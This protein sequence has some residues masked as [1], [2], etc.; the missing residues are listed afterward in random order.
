MTA[1]KRGQRGDKGLHC[2]PTTSAPESP[3]G[4]CYGIPSQGGGVTRWGPHGWGIQ[5]KLAKFFSPNFFF[6]V[7][8]LWPQKELTSLEFPAWSTLPA[9]RGPGGGGADHPSA[10]LPK[11]GESRCWGVKEEASAPN[12]GLS[13]VGRSGDGHWA[14]ERPEARSWG[15]VGAE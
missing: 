14:T 3:K 5:V 7:G 1:G 12:R 13:G 4:M 10:H 6:T 2:T 11:V 8:R 9:K 15:G